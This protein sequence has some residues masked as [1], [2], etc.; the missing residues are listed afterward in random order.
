MA[1]VD[2]PQTGPTRGPVAESS[3]PR[4]LPAEA[5]RPRGGHSAG[6]LSHRPRY[7]GSR[8]RAGARAPA[9][10]RSRRLASQLSSRPDR[11]AA[12]LTI[13][14]SAAQLFS[15]RFFPALAGSVSATSPARP[16]DSGGWFSG[17]AADHSGSAEGSNKLCGG[18]LGRRRGRWTGGLPESSGSRRSASW[19]TPAPARRTSP[20]NA[21]ETRLSRRSACAVPVRTGATGW[22]SRGTSP[23]RAES[24]AWSSSAEARTR[25]A[26]RA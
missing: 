20:W 17:E 5:G 26:T 10:P 2:L 23:S 15:D 25:P 19:R 8:Q 21:G 11:G 4:V 22:S 6:S 12:D 18:S 1:G 9:R 13:A 3:R 7:Q 14:S 16:E 24:R